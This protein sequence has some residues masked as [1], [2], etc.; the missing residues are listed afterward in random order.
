[1]NFYLFTVLVLT[2][3]WGFLLAIN[4]IPDYM[5]LEEYRR[6]RRKARRK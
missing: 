3:L 6:P 5:L 2:F 4:L 1:M